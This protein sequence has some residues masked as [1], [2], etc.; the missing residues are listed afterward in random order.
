MRKMMQIQ[1]KYSSIK[2]QN[3]YIIKY[4]NTIIIIAK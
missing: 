2:L 4:V 3:S 1:S